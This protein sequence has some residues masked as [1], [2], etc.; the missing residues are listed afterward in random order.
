MKI[1]IC[2]TGFSHDMITWPQCKILVDDQVH[3]DQT[4]SST[5]NII[6]NVDLNE[7]EN[8]KISILQYGKMFGENRVWHTKSVEGKIISDRY[9]VIND[10][11]FDD[12]SIKKIWYN[13]CIN[14]Q[15]NEKQIFDFTQNNLDVPYFESLPKG[16]D[17]I[18]ISYNGGYVLDFDTPIY[19]WII[20]MQSPL[21]KIEG[22]MKESS[23]T[24]IVTWRLDYSK[25]N[26][27]AELYNECID[28]LGKVK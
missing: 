28:L 9:L 2:L 16:Y 23:L 3:I 5:Q 17:E 22:K 21:M 7:S 19:D 18:R 6:F 25:G 10:I 15:F 4:I 8:H 27:L 11:K 1:E 12:V 13:G 20:K 14:N 24:S 26:S